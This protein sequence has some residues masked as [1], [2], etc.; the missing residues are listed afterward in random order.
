MRSGDLSG[1][2]SS[3]DA[4]KKHE[5]ARTAN[6]S[7]GSEGATPKSARDREMER[8]SGFLTGAGG[9]ILGFALLVRVSPSV[10]T[11]VAAGVLLLHALA[12]PA[13][14]L[15]IA[16]ALIGAAV[17]LP[18]GLR[19]V[20]LH[21]SPLAL[22]VGALLAAAGLLLARGS[23]ASTT[24]RPDTD[25]RSAIAAGLALAVGLAATARTALRTAGDDPGACVFV[26]WPL[27]AAAGL[28][29][30]I[31]G[32]LARRH[33][34]LAPH[35][36]G[37][38]TILAL[39][40]FLVEPQPLGDVFALAE[41]IQGPSV[42]RR[43]FLFGASLLSGAIGGFLAF[44]LGALAATVLGGAGSARARCVTAAAIAL[45]P[46]VP[47]PLPWGAAFA[48]VVPTRL[49]PGTTAGRL[50][51][52]LAWGLVLAVV[53][54]VR[55][56]AWVERSTPAPAVDV[57]RTFLVD[58]ASTPGWPL[59]V[60]VAGPDDPLTL[61]SPEAVLKPHGDERPA[62]RIGVAVDL[63][64][65]AFPELRLVARLAVD[66]LDA[67]VGVLDGRRIVFV[68][69]AVNDVAATPGFL[70]LSPAAV[71]ALA[72][73]GDSGPLER[74]RL[75]PARTRLHPVRPD[76]AA[77]NLRRL[78]RR[79]DR[80]D[81]DGGAP[82]QRLR[83][84]LAVA[85]LE[86]DAATEERLLDR[87]EGTD[88]VAAR[89]LRAARDDGRERLHDFLVAARDADP[90]DADVRHRLGLVYVRSGRLLAGLTE[91]TQAFQL[92]SKLLAAAIDLIEAYVAAEAVGEQRWAAGGKLLPNVQTAVAVHAMIRRQVE[93][94]ELIA[95]LHLAMA[96]VRRLEADRP[97]EA[98]QADDRLREAFGRAN[99]A[100]LHDPTDADA[101]R[102]LAEALLGRA[103]R[104]EA[105]YQHAREAARLEPFDVRNHLVS[106]RAAPGPEERR[107]ALAAALA[108]GLTSTR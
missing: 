96:A 48:A 8:T 25:G 5:R 60:A 80:L 83:L 49:G 85:I 28:G 104:P 95:Q 81:P 108:N 13:E 32:L 46:L 86:D 29:A 63:G 107:R 102:A 24:N 21:G 39:V 14:R 69:E 27:L 54:R 57:I 7:T 4:A 26:L 6:D 23:R 75:R 20:A 76:L 67:P 61:L 100:L 87:L 35:L 3:A 50:A 11:A 9:G 97:T 30:A 19:L 74:L 84:S 17:G 42:T 44:A 59:P 88:T 2:F 82:E 72:A 66:R 1:G 106:A 92:R 15:S 65:R 101:H 53:L 18:L 90:A 37:V 78:I 73:E 103:I 31:A 79:A 105:A 71:A 77:A 91:L 40:A 43:H 47:V 93:D 64:T 34:R 56:D 62:T 33:A 38:V 52:A 45:L 51:G 89:A 16:G 41:R 22:G 98:N 12:A 94:P 10:A 36:P 55:S 68:S 99:F 70:A 58:E